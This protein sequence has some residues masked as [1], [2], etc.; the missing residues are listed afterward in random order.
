MPYLC[1]RL[2]LAHFYRMLLLMKKCVINIFGIFGEILL[3]SRK[4]GRIK[5]GLRLTFIVW[6][7]FIIRPIMLIFCVGFTVHILSRIFIHYL[8]S[9]SLIRIIA[10][11][12]PK[13][14]AG[15][16]HRSQP[17]YP[18]QP[19]AN[20]SNPSHY[21]DV[22]MSAMPSQITGVSIVCSTVQLIKAPRHWP[23]CREF[24]DDRWIPHTK[25]HQRRKCFHL[26]KS[27]WKVIYFTDCMQGTCFSLISCQSSRVHRK[28]FTL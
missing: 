19:V 16:L 10:A 18:A 14:A 15:I 4:L 6:Y 12:Y 7:F 27:S 13:H 8:I 3:K 28:V 9:A 17:I 21:N 24:T 26:M 20:H 5:G 22:T 11:R 1:D 23:L 2:S 25:G